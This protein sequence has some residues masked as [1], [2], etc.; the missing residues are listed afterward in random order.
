MDMDVDTRLQRLEKLVAMT[1][2]ASGSSLPV[3]SVATVFVGDQIGTQDRYLDLYQNNY[4]RLVAVKVVAEFVLPGSSVDLSLQLTDNG[5]ID[6]LSSAG[7]VISETIWLK[8]NQT[9]Y[10][11]TADTAF[12]LNGSTFR[13]LLFDPISFI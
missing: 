3:T 10:I 4:P 6:T 8:P 11:N 7:K 9:L 2:L 1:L 5:K 13:V 12:T